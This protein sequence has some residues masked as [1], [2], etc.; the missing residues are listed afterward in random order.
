[1]HLIWNMIYVLRE[2]QKQNKAIYFAFNKTYFK[3]VAI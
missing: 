3:K 2:N 1:M